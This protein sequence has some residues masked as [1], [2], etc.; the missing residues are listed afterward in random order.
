MICGEIKMPKMDGVE[1]VPGIF[2][3][4]EPAPIPG[5]PK[6]RCLANVGGALAIVELV[7]KFS[8]QEGAIH[9]HQA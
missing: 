1:I 3:I 9:V 8:K 4:G 5:S 6:L 7:L 2:L